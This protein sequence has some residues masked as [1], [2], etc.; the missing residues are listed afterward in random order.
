VLGPRVLVG[1]LCLTLSVWFF[2]GQAIAQAASA[3][4]YSLIDNN[5]SDLGSTTCGSITVL[6]YTAFTCS[7]WHVVMNVTFVVVGLLTI[8]GMLATHR[9]W[10]QGRLA[11]LGVAL[12]VVSGF[13]EMLAGF[14]PEDVHPELHVVGAI[15]GIGFS[16]MGIVLLG[17]T[18]WSVE[19]R[20]GIGSILLGGLGL[21][22]FLVARSLGVPTG[23]A[24]R[25]ASYPTIIWQIGVGVLVLSQGVKRNRAYSLASSDR[26]PNT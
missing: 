13:G 15:L 8:A 23:A 5:I 24:E 6:T 25:L 17:V 9:I 10:P 18:A 3:A 22:G 11:A 26:S 19:R 14:S 21:F 2:V 12:V 1:A 16:A 20:V 4:P 7:P